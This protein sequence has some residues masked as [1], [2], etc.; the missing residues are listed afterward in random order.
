MRQGPAD[1]RKS[2]SLP[3]VPAQEIPVL[4]IHTTYILPLSCLLIY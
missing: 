1:V 3:Y 2:V 4:R